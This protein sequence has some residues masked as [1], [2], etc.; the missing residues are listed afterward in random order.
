MIVMAFN[1]C[2]S[3]RC[4]VWGVNT[5]LISSISIFVIGELVFTST[6]WLLMFSVIRPRI[7][8]LKQEVKPHVL[9]KRFLKYKYVFP[10]RLELEKI[11]SLVADLKDLYLV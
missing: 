10:E 7:L 9:V 5:V 8:Y 6:I 2:V 4:S 3:L 1:A 11:C